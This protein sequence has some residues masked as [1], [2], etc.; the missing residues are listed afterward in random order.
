MLT[1]FIV[2]GVLPEKFKEALSK[3]KVERAEY[4]AGFVMPVHL[5]FPEAFGNDV[6][7][8]MLQAELEGEEEESEDD[9]QEGEEEES[10]D[11]GQEEENGEA[12]E[13]SED[14]AQEGQGE[15]SGE[16]DEESG[17]SE[18]EDQV[19][20]SQDKFTNQEAKAIADAMNEDFDEDPDSQAILKSMEDDF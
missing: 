9:D 1:F 8:W 20:N 6:D 13:E 11:D 3:V 19:D 10:E 12:E 17:G 14:D 7:D 5:L 18:G 4:F 2:S 15:E 16:A